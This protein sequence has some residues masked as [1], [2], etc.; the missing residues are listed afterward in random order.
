MFRERNSARYPGKDRLAQLDRI[1]AF[2]KPS[3]A[4]HCVSR[5]TNVTRFQWKSWKQ[6]PCAPLLPDQPRADC[7]SLVVPAEIFWPQFRFSNA[8]RK[9]SRSVNLSCA[10]S[11]WTVTQGACDPLLDA[12]CSKNATAITL[13]AGSDR[14]ISPSSASSGLR[15]CE[16]L[17]RMFWLPR[18][19]MGARFLSV[20]TPSIG[21]KFFVTS[22][23]SPENG[24]TSEFQSLRS[25]FACGP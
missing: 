10:K 14:T 16:L 21:R 25:P 17:A 3:I 15:Y 11:A 12:D 22:C 13:D 4:K 5:G 23:I 7:I 18:L 2:G 19:G 6:R 1:P 8:A 24:R 9:T 20:R